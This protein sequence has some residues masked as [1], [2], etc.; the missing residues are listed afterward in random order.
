MSQLLTLFFVAMCVPFWA[1][2]QTPSKNIQEKESN[3]KNVISKEQ[4][5]DSKDNALSDDGKEDKS[6]TLSWQ[7]QK[8]I[9][10]LEG[11]RREATDIEDQ[12]KKIKL[13]VQVADALWPYDI[14]A[15]RQQFRDTFHDV[16]SIDSNTKKDSQREK[17]DLKLVKAQLRQYIIQV[18]SKRDP[19]LAD[20]LAK[21]VSIKKPANNEAKNDGLGGEADD[22]S[23]NLRLL[24]AL[25][26]A[27]SKPDMA[28]GIATETLKTGISPLLIR[29]LRT[30]RQ[31]DARIADDVYSKM[32][33][34][35]RNDKRFYN[36]DTLLLLGLYV[37]E[38]ERGVRQATRQAT[39]MYLRF[40]YGV[41]L[42]Q[43][44]TQMAGEPGTTGKNGVENGYWILQRLIPLFEQFLPEEA[45]TVKAVFRELSQKVSPS[46]RSSMPENSKASQSVDE[47]LQMADE[48]PSLEEKDKIRIRATMLAARQGDFEKALFIVE[49]LKEYED[50]KIVK[51]MVLDMAVDKAISSGDFDTAHVYAKEIE[52]LEHRWRAFKELA[53]L[54]LSKKDTSKAA[55]LLLEIQKYLVDSYDTEAEKALGHFSIAEAF[56][57]F[58]LLQGFDAAS[59]AIKSL[60]NADFAKLPQKRSKFAPP[61]P[62]IERFNFEP[63]LAPLARND[64]DKTLAIAQAINNKE[65]FVLAQIAVCR[66]ALNAIDHSKAKSQPNN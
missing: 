10:I 60:N 3:K 24:L 8:A 7:Q 41:V 21:S 13:Q 38:D 34:L 12:E 39:E 16:D 19:E 32:L 45:N 28:A 66:T 1:V 30:L 33:L 57:K 43:I 31:K 25:D 2:Q 44:E 62:T 27:E 17:R 56:V 18:L 22:P 5:S 20:N 9:G 61:F 50:K 6:R 37:A 15:S 47:L 48:A 65:A 59:L 54:S 29:V 58:D 23:V 46:L 53:L 14:Q 52:S 11:L 36:F 35:A 49:K 51:S 42:F 26:I 40:A 63:V 4:K 55:S 64:F